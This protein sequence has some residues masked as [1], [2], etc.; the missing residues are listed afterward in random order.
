MKQFKETIEWTATMNA[1]PIGIEELVHDHNVDFVSRQT[2][3]WEGCRGWHKFQGEPEELKKLAKALFRQKGKNLCLR[4]NARIEPWD[5]YWKR[6]IKLTDEE[7]GRLIDFVRKAIPNGLKK[8]EF[9][10]YQPPDA[11]PYEIMLRSEYASVEI[12]DATDV[13]VKVVMSN[14]GVKVEMA[15]MCYGISRVDSRFELIE[16][17]WKT[18]QEWL[19]PLPD[20]VK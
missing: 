3:I 1:Y 18:M 8:T 6:A 5:E 16:K 7:F 14:W 17:Q 12:P 13:A 11:Q 4:L 9:K 20:V 19:A 2:V 10:H 15:I